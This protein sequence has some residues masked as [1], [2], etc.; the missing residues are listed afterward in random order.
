MSGNWR[1]TLKPSS[2]D[3]TLALP[4]G[5]VVLMRWVLPTGRDK[6]VFVGICRIPGPRQP[7]TAIKRT[8]HEGGADNL[9][10]LG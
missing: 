4:T 2:N 7:R 5:Y 10:H 9:L 8:A 1:R 3:R 6:H